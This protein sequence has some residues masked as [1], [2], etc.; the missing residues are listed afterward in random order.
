MAGGKKET[1]DT[2]YSSHLT[3]RV[4]VVSL[5]PISRPVPRCHARKASMP[6]WF[7]NTMGMPLDSEGRQSFCFIT[8]SEAV[9][10]HFLTGV[11]YS[12]L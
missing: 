7:R 9:G 3:S 1:L 6:H 5:D 10:T 4:E 2:Q 8:L 11:E 12:A